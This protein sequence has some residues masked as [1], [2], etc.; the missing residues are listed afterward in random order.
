VRRLADL[1]SSFILSSCVGVVQGLANKQNE[2]DRQGKSQ[3]PNQGQ[4]RL[5]LAK[6]LDSLRYPSFPFDA[7]AVA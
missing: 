5:V 1:A 6:H 7:R 3:H 2:Q 4:S